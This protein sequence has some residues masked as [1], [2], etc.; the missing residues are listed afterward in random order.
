MHGLQCCV[1]RYSSVLSVGDSPPPMS[2]YY[3]DDLRLSE[4]GAAPTRKASAR[5]RLTYIFCARALVMVVVKSM[6]D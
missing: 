3:A 4:A 6:H 2:A 5:L 1:F